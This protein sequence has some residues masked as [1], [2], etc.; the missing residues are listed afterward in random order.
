MILRHPLWPDD[1][2]WD[3]REEYDAADLVEPTLE[4]PEEMPEPECEARIQQALIA[5]MAAARKRKEKA[6]GE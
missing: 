6:D 5:V 4:N 2:G 1:D 3:E